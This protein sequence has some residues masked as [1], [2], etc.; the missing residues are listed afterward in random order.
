MGKWEKE[1][2][3]A[4]LLAA[5]FVCDTCLDSARSAGALVL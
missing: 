4:N 2:K 5:V 1:N 3:R